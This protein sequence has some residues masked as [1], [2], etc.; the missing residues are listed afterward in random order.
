MRVIEEIQIDTIHTHLKIKKSG[1]SLDLSSMPGRAN[2]Y[3][4][5]RVLLDTLDVDNL[6]LWFEFGKYTLDENCKITALQE[7]ARS[8]DR[9]KSFTNVQFDLSDSQN[10]ELVILTDDVQ[11]DVLYII[12][13]NHRAIA[14][15]LV[16]ND[17]Y[18]VP[19]FVCSHPELLS[20]SYIPSPYKRSLGL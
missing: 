14:Q 16:H 7:S 13:G 8:L 18:D 12:D 1:V 6:I 4:G 10:M 11:S 17:F 20:W 3:K 19:A 9:V 5:H 2:E 15:K